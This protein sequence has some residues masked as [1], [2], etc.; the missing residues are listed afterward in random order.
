MN[1][2]TSLWRQCQLNRI[3]G[4]YKGIDG[5]YQVRGFDISNMTIVASDNGWVVIDA[6]TTEAVARAAINLMEEHL[7]QLSIK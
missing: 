2:S 6:L 7:G 4:L 1:G 5:I 3:R